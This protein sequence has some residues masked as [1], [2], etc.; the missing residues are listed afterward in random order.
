MGCR[1]QVENLTE[2]IEVHNMEENDSQAKVQIS[3]D[4][5]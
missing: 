3:N 4:Y 5:I 1:D 2:L